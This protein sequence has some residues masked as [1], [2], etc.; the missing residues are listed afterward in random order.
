MREI[1]MTAFDTAWDLV[2][3]PYHGTS[4]S[5]AE[6]MFNEGMKPRHSD[7]YETWFGRPALSFATPDYDAAL[8]YA[9]AA[10]D[11][12]DPPAV[13]YIDPDV[14]FDDIHGTPVG[15]DDNSDMEEVL[16]TDQVI[17]PEMLSLKFMGD[18]MKEGEDYLE[19]RE[20]MNRLMNQELKRYQES[21]EYFDEF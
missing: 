17:P 10:M 19:Y 14:P 2:K 13:V 18:R 11:R 16:I 6:S 15:R 5:R 4:Y 12:N 1:Q 21:E 20:R 9:M 3:M 7:N 8:D